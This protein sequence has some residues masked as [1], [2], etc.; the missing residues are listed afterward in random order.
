M[1]KIG[2]FSKLAHISVRM[3]RHYDQIGLLHPRKIDDDSG[4]R[5]YSADQLPI[6]NKIHKLKELGFGLSLI[7]ELIQQ[8]LGSD[9]AEQYFRL[10]KA[11]LQ[12]EL[13]KLE[14]QSSLLDSA[15]QILKKDV[16]KMKYHVITKEIPQRNV[17]SIRKTMPNY[18]T[19]GLLWEEFYQKIGAHEP[20]IA[21][22]MEKSPENLCIAIYHDLEYKESDVDVEL[23]ST[24]IGSYEDSND[25]LAFKT[26]S[27][28]K[29][30]SV[31]FN[32]P[33][34]QMM[35]ITEV[36]AKWVEDN[37]L[38]LAGP[39]FNIYHVSPAT[40]PNPDN[41]VTEACFPIK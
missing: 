33:Y 32:G 35:E 41:W 19:E 31:T 10:R 17:V 34:E 16:K 20:K 21:Y 3:L 30:A 38:S 14:K 22:S 25:G 23:Q 28:F 37:Q 24:V 11:E 2:E 40:D 26:T 29:V 18:F 13:A 27:A 9:K 6:I 36:A 8:D 12:D 1:F 5:Y 15:A 39:M 7:G 4:Y